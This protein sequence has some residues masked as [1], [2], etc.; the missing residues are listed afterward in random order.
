[1]MHPAA[2]SGQVYPRPR[3][4]C[5]MSVTCHSPRWFCDIESHC[6]QSVMPNVPVSQ[7]LQAP[8]KFTRAQIRIRHPRGTTTIELDL[9]TSLVD[10]LRVLIFS[11][12]EIP[13]SEQDSQSNWSAARISLTAVE[14]NMATHP[15]LFH[16]WRALCPLSQLVGANRSQ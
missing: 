2:N 11:A 4:P 14:S 16:R 15:N 9:E 3:I 8:A 13:P 7:P 5:R 12:T 6:P 10:D 1:M